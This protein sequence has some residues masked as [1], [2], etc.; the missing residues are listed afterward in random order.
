M[1][2]SELKKEIQASLDEGYTLDEIQKV[3]IE[4][5]YP[6][7]TVNNVIS[8]FK[9][10]QGTGFNDNKSSLDGPSKTEVNVGS[11]EKENSNNGSGYRIKGKHRSPVRVVIFTV[12]TIGI[13]FYYWEYLMYKYGLSEK[14]ESNSKRRLIAIGLWIISWIPPVILF[15]WPYFFAKL[16][17]LSEVD[18]DKIAYTILYF[19]LFLTVIG[20]PI[21]VY[22]IQSDIN[23]G[24]ESRK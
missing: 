20:G 21:A 15:T 16:I 2:R 11:S 24:I 1:D 9:S 18:K 10:T 12:L 5:G 14:Y 19:I 8:D 7:K 4:E 17:E 13:Y 3:L 22:L 6:Q 23:K